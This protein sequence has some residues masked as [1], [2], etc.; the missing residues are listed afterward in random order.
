[1]GGGV[2]TPTSSVCKQNIIINSNNYYTN[3]TRITLADTSG[4]VIVS[5]LNPSNCSRSATALMSAAGIVLGTQYRILTGG[6]VS[7]GETHYELTIGG[8]ISGGTQVTAITPSTTV[9]G[10]GTGGGPGGRW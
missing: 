8:S 5:L 3:G 7:G 10:G 1:M 2:S 4:N 9:T 6:T